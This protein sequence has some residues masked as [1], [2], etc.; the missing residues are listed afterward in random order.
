[1]DLKENYA[2]NH[3]K[4][5]TNTLYLNKRL[6]NTYNTII[7]KL[8]N[9]KLQGINIDLGSGDKGFTDYLKS[10]GINSYPYD[11]PQFDLE[12]DILQHQENT[13]DFITMNAVIEHISDPEHILDEIKRVLRPN[14]FLFIRTPNWQMDF[15]NFY[16]D[17]THIKP[18]APETLRNTL[19]LAGLKCIFLE[20]GLIHKNWF[21]W[22]LPTAFKWRVASLL[23]G[24]TKSVLAIGMKEEKNNE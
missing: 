23:K 11:Y 5:D 15:K 22:Q 3:A 16:N 10:I 1:M 18:Y 6:F 21:W 9:R 14:G 24:G 2:K 8:F 7:K 12:K 4:I 17:P 19:H 13:I 20:P